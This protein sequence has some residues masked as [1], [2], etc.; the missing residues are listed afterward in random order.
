MQYILFKITIFLQLSMELS[1]KML[2][3]VNDSAQMTR[4]SRILAQ[5][6]RDINRKKMCMLQGNW[7]KMF[8][9]PKIRIKMISQWNIN[10]EGSSIIP[11][12]VVPL[13]QDIPIVHPHSAAVLLNEFNKYVHTQWDLTTLRVKTAILS[14]KQFCLTMADFRPKDIALCEWF[15]SYSPNCGHGWR[16]TWPCGRLYNTFGIVGRR[17]CCASL[18]IQQRISANT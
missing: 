15:Q 1:T 17:N 16:C 6:R 5:I 4:L 11:L 3:Q 13:Y 7:F 8:F 12:C 14:I 18:P 2:S 9:F 10:V